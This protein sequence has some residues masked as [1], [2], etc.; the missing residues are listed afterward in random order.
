MLLA[1]KVAAAILAVVSAQMSWVNGDSPNAVAY[2]AQIHEVAEINAR[3]AKPGLLVSPDV[4]QLLLAS[5]QFYE[6]SWNPRAMGDCRGKQCLSGGLMGV[7]RSLSPWLRKEVG[8]P[9]WKVLRDPESNVLAGYRWLD[10]RQE[11]CGGSI[12]FWLESYRYRKCP[13]RANELRQ[14]KLRCKFAERLA[15]EVGVEFSC[16]ADS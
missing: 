16:S 4:D 13:A 5:V 7:H 1:S 12:E 14:G 11:Q 3:V 15:R 6:A 8:L 2:R 10:V 9:W